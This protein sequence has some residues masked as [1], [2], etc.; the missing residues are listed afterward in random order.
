MQI[1][2]TITASLPVA[3]NP[4]LFQEMKELLTGMHRGF[5]GYLQSTGTIRILKGSWD[6]ATN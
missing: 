6:F 3:E 2:A 5:I 4:D 1:T